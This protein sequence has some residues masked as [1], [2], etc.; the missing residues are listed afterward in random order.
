M[1]LSIL[2]KYIVG[3]RIFPFKQSYDNRLYPLL[4]LVLKL[5]CFVIM[6]QAIFQHSITTLARLR[7][8]W[9]G[10]GLL[11]STVQ[12][13]KVRQF[14]SC[15]GRCFSVL[16]VPNQITPV[17]TNRVKSKGMMILFGSKWSTVQTCVRKPQ[18]LLLC[19]QCE[20]FWVWWQVLTCIR[21]VVNQSLHSGEQ[22]DIAI[23]QCFITEKMSSEIGGNWEPQDNF[24]E[25][26]WHILAF[27]KIKKI[28]SRQKHLNWCR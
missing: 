17:W 26:I 20:K 22:C 11:T 12:T 13:I 5:V 2:C 27:G 7:Q 28:S 4:C 18:A 10:Q 1:Y 19:Q 21:N 24:V 3:H 23:R 14:S 15:C 9:E 25:E 16:H 8:V 6:Y